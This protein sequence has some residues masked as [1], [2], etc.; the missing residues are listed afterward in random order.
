MM[1]VTVGPSVASRILRRTRQD[2]GERLQGRMRQFAVPGGSTGPQS[3]DV[4]DVVAYGGVA[5]T[6]GLLAEQDVEHA[7]AG[8]L[9]N[10]PNH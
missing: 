6:A 3:H 4:E 8:G 1:A 10:G 5:Q 2:I 7:G 9:L